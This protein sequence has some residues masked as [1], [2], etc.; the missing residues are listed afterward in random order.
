MKCRFVKMIKSIILIAATLG[1]VNANTPFSETTSMPPKPFRTGFYVGAELGDFH[2]SYKYKENKTGRTYGNGVVFTST[3]SK[4]RNSFLP[5]LFAGYRHAICPLFLGFELSVNPN[6]M[7]SKISFM[8]LFGEKCDHSVK[9]KYNI[10]PALLLGGP[11]SAINGLTVYGK[12]GCDFG[13]YHHKMVES[14][15][16]GQ[17]FGLVNN[18]KSSSK[19]TRSLLL[20][21]GI[22]YALNETISSR[23][24]FI[25]SF[26]KSMKFYMSKNPQ[27]DNS[28]KAFVKPSAT[29][30]KVGFFIK[31][32]N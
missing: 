20:G 22:E 24:E 4:N 32:K 14:V 29:A 27:W 5:G 10:I 23:F 16:S 1:V 28:Y 18:S 21:L 26:G 25:H 9:A 11:I 7:Q 12:I 6:K 17:F 31:I 2:G 3:G 30:F 8:G 15:S 13:R 19:S